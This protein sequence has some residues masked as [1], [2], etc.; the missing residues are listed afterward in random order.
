MAGRDVRTQARPAGCGQPGLG[1]KRGSVSAAKLIEFEDG[2]KVFASSVMEA[3][4]LYD[5]IFRAGCY[6]HAGLPQR[7]LV[8][9][10]G[11]NIGMFTLFIK[12]RYPDAE[13]LAFEPAPQTAAVLRQNIGLHGLAGITVHEVALGS[14]PEQAAAFTFFPA[15]PGGSTRYPEQTGPARAAVS[16]MFSARVA[17][18]LYRGRD[19]VVPVERLSAF[20]AAGRPV[21]LLK[22]DVEGAELDV[23]LSIDPAQWPLIRQAILEVPDHPSRVAEVCDLL[24]SHG[25]EPSAGPGPQSDTDSPS[26]VV[27]A[28]RR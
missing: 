1:G 21:D 17:D 6:E 27:H 25:L 28:V 13:I 23:L 11:A 26:R 20:L 24:S 12:R 7:P 19:I 18:R 4:F 5:E 10:A 9:D 16:R 2:L 22:I 3:R 14:Q 8:V 15:A